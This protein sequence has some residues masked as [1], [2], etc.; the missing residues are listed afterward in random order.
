MS[1][2]L[3]EKCKHLKC[4]VVDEMPRNYHANRKEKNFGVN[5]PFVCIWML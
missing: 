3:G 1:Y 2:I 5:F 4:H